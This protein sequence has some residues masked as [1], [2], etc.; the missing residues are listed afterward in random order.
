MNPENQ[1]KNKVYNERQT[2]TKKAYNA[3]KSI[4]KALSD[5]QWH[6][7]KELLSTTKLNFR[8]L[9]KHLTTMTKNQLIERDDKK[10]INGKHAILYK[11]ES[12]TL[13]YIE[14]SK[15]DEQFSNNIDTILE[16]TKNNP[17]I[18]LD[19]IHQLNQLAFLIILEKIQKNK[20]TTT[21]EDVEYLEDIYMEI[22]Y[23]ILTRMLMKATI[24]IIDKI[25]IEQIQI[26]T[27]KMQKEF[28]EIIMRNYEE[29]GKT[30]ETF[31][32]KYVT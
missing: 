1:N 28:W 10:I 20:E 25:D 11:A 3:Q 23:Q 27:A 17:L 14:L 21:W 7:K 26:S 24:K 8:T 18:I 32:F 29:L 4:F 6:Q 13:S 12:H 30:N 9:D 15:L 5:G 31:K 16:E 2:N 19:M 22:H